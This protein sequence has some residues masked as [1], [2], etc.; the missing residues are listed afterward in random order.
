MQAS[1]KLVSP[2][3]HQDKQAPVATFKNSL[4]AWQTRYKTQRA[5]QM[6][7]RQKPPSQVAPAY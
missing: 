7:F 5:T 2:S 1:K 4:R 3:V 6:A